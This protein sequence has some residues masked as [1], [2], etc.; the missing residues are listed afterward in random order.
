MTIFFLD[1][2]QESRKET[3]IEFCQEGGREEE[4]VR[5]SPGLAKEWMLAKAEGVIIGVIRDSGVG[6][7]HLTG[8]QRGPFSVRLGS[9]A[10]VVANRPVSFMEETF[11]VATGA[12]G[13]T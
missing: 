7:T 11:I 5:L 9:F 12:H 6:H 13:L 2:L 8:E 1:K 3:P 10:G 4:S